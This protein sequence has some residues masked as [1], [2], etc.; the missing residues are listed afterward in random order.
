MVIMIGAL[1]HY[2]RQTINRWLRRSNDVT[3]FSIPWTFQ[4]D[5][6]LVLV[7]MLT[8][9]PNECSK[10][11][12]NFFSTSVIFLHYKTNTLLVC[13][14]FFN[15]LIDFNE[16]WLELYAN[17]ITPASYVLILSVSTN[18]A[19]GLLRQYLHN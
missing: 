6:V 5:V 3:T 12:C 14:S 9:Q 4:T 2:V 1:L 7:H 16:M 13:V 19:S 8:V 10:S 17:E 18:M 15:Q 11:T